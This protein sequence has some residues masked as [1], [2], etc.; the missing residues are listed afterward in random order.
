MLMEGKSA[1]EVID[2]IDVK[3]STQDKKTVG[4]RRQRRRV[5]A[6]IDCEF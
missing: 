5:A 3:Y 4:V 6:L 2:F 1:A